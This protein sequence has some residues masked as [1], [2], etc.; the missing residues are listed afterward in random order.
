MRNGK[1]A[2]CRRNA[3][4]YVWA[5]GIYLEARLEDEKQCILVSDRCH[6]GGQEGARRL[7][8]RCQGKCPRLA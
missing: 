2:I 1:S 3:Y 8:R 4:V 7:H 6:A 5:D